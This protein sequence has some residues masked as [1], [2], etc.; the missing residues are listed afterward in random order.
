MSTQELTRRERHGRPVGGSRRTPAARAPG[1]TR[2]PRAHWGL[3]AVVLVVLGLALAL[4]STVAGVGPSGTEP[5]GPEVAGEGRAGA[6]PAG[7]P[8]LALADGE[9]V[10]TGL[11]ERT[12]ALTFED[13]PDPRWTPELLDAL[14]AEGVP[15]TFFV[16]GARVAEHPELVRRIRA[17]GHEVGVHGWSHADLAALPDWRRNLE[18]SLGQLSLAGADGVLSALLRPPATGTPEDLHAPAVSAATA[19]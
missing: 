3:L 19:A 16:T 9:L 10:G 11:P 12:V 8:V 14:A 1:R 6:L 15:A 17:E 13:G 4:E 2:T 7:G 5:S 18:L